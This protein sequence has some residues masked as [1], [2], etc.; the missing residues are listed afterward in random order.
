MPGSVREWYS[1]AGADTRLTV[2]EIEYR[3]EP[4]AR[5]LTSTEEEWLAGVWGRPDLLPFL[6]VLDVRGEVNFYVR[7]HGGDDPGVFDGVD[8]DRMDEPFSEF[9]L[10]IV[11]EILGER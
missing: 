2:P 5:S 3:Q 11:G 7:L 1:L 10:G 6:F 4:L 8:P 9:V